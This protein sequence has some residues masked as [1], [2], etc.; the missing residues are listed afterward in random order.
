MSLQFFQSKNCLAHLEKNRHP[1]DLKVS[2]FNT[3]FLILLDGFTNTL[4]IVLEWTRS[5]VGLERETTNLKVAGSIPAGS[6]FRN[7]YFARRSKKTYILA[8]S[9]QSKFG[10]IISVVILKTRTGYN[11]FSPLGVPIFLKPHQSFFYGVSH[12]YFGLS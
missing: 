11:A 2:L 3:L 7:S 8:A 6:E 10:V 5:S 12:F 1:I 4:V 9:N